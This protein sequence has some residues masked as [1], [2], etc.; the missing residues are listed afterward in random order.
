M[1]GKNILETFIDDFSK[2]TFIY[3][4]KTKFGVFDKLKVFKTLVVN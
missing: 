2:K 1:E 3:T 4:M